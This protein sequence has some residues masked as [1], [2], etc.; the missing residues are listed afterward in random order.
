MTCLHDHRIHRIIRPFPPVLLILG[1]VVSMPTE[2]AAGE[3]RPTE[4]TVKPQYRVLYNQ[5]CTNLFDSGGKL[6]PRDVQQMVDEVAHGGADVL[7]VNPN[8]QLVNYPS[9][10]WQTFWEGYKQ[11]DR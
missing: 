8:A 11:G 1:L 10:V 3:D 9:K 2:R 4:K 6:A 7:L 5:D